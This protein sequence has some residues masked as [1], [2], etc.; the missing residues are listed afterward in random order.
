[1]F[2]FVVGVAL[3][4]LYGPTIAKADPKKMAALLSGLGG[5][6]AIALGALLSVRGG[7]IIGGPLVLLGAGALFP[8]LRMGAWRRRPSYDEADAESEI[9]T[10][11]VRMR[12]HRPTGAMDGVVKRGPHQ[13][14][15]L[16][17]LHEADVRAV[18]AEAEADDPDGAA[19]L[20]AYIDR[21]FNRASSGGTRNGGSRGGTQSAP[22][23]PGAMGEDEALSVL[24]LQRGATPDQIR[25]A[26]RRLMVKNHP[27]QGGSSWFA[28]KINAAR[29]RLLGKR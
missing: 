15:R 9:D 23:A 17:D 3:V 22:P 28:A 13:N 19:V 5:A 18:F 11:S 29:D 12:L 20:R 2:I 16:S 27:D 26:H 25:E 6:I 7:V 24:G 8:G 4:M 1:M 14:K 10:P 21:R